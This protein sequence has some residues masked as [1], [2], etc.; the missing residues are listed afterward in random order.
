[1]LKK[2]TEAYKKKTSEIST[3]PSILLAGASGV[4]KR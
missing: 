3:K 4:G 1:L 2:F